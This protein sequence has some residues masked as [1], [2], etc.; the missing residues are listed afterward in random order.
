MAY[1]THTIG[2]RAAALA[3]APRVRKFAIW[4]IAIALALGVLGALV[5]P[6]VLRRVLSDQLTAKLH[7]PVTIDRISINPYAMTATLEGFLMKERNG[8][9][10]AIS[11]DELH[12]NLQLMSLFRWGVVVRE[13]RLVRPYV[14]LV[15]QE[16]FKYN[17]QDLIDEFTAQP[18]DPQPPAGDPAKPRFAFY[19]IQISQGKIDFDDRPEKTQHSIEN[20][21][22][23]IPFI[24]SLPSD[25]DIFVKPAFAA[26]VNGTPLDIKGETKPFKDSL[27]SVVH[28]NIDDLQIP[29]YVEYSPVNLAFTVPSGRIDGKLTA[30]FKSIKGQ[31]ASFDIAADLGLRDLVMQEKAGEPL[32]KLPALDVGVDSFGIFAKKAAVKTVKVQGLEL[33]LKRRK[34]GSFNFANL[35]MA[36]ANPSEAPRA[37]QAD[38]E[39]AKNAATA[40]PFRYQIE[41]LLLESG[42]LHYTDETTGKPYQTRFDDLRIDIKNL[43]NEPGKKAEVEIA[44]ESTA[45]E[46]FSHNGALQLTPLLAE[47]KL[48]V[49]GLRPGGFKPYYEDTLAAEVRDGFLDLSTRYFF[50]QTDKGGDFKLTELAA[51]LRNLRLEE[52]G[53][54]PLWRVPHLAVKDASV[55]AGNKIVV[56]GSLEG[57]EASGFIQRSADGTLNY[58][59]LVKTQPAAPAAKAAVK[60]DDPGW[61]IEAKQIR[62]NRFKIDFEDHVPARPARLSVSDLS[63]RGERFSNIKNQRG[64]ATI[65]AKINNGEVRLN[66][67]A[68]ADPLVAQFQVEGRN[69]EIAPLQPYLED[70]VNFILTGGR[71]GTKGN[72]I[73]DASAQGPAKVTYNGELGVSDFS[74]VEKNASED[75]LNW[76]LLTLGGIQ[77]AADPM[78]VR[79]DQVDLAGFYS[80]LVLGAD[81]KINLQNLAVD[82]PAKSDDAA[83]AATAEPETSQ[84]TAREA[85]QPP[86]AAPA[87]A[88][89]I[90]IGEIKLREGNINFS[91]FFVKPNYTA[92]LTGVQGTIAELK[93]EAPGDLALEAKLDNAAPVDIRGKINPLGKELF[94][95]IKAKASEIELSAFSP[96]SGKYVGYG[97][98]KGQLT[99]D[100]A[101]KLENRKLDA[102]TQFILNQLTFGEKIDSPTAIN[103]PVTLAV[104]LLKDRNGVIDVGLPISGTLDDPQFSVGGIIWRLIVNIITRAVTA[105]FALLGAAFGGGGGAE[106]SYIEFEYGR[107]SLS[108]TAE[109]K[110]KTLATAMNNRPGLKLEITGRAE[111]T[112]DSEGLKRVSL[113]NKVRAQK[114]KELA[115]QGTAPSSVEE[116][117]VSKEEYERL[118]RAAYDAETFPKPRNL[119]GLAQSLPVAEMENLILKHTQISDDDVRALANRRAQEVRERLL[120]ANIA[121]D[122]LFV[123]AG[124]PPAKE[125]PGKVKARPSRVD[126][127]LR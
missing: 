96:Y 48:E 14:N 75:L 62:L 12:V 94:M 8:A 51:T 111:P 26:V 34:D 124:K 121:A 58:A 99:F 27:E 72:F 40:T 65:Q 11:F 13:L 115:R 30:S 83:A 20:L 1:P 6:Y 10:T 53:N 100:V 35:T 39:P 76:K 125:E 66:G 67:S 43:D 38:T 119:I 7:R 107:T 46:R 104:A 36:P 114:I 85:P 81:G 22:L 105:P 2:G 28:I 42:K 49:E 110:I 74:I 113:E 59:R 16:D 108:Q 112:S 126:F 32:L 68:A 5:A 4:F 89:K 97:I 21:Q 55:D 117:Q 116:V 37:S 71:V 88:E 98:E 120:A 73:F 127:S 23:G 63:V 54:K 31:D 123:V 102:Q 44:F 64:K 60:K 80:R 92:N 87:N 52:T 91:D 18:P 15:R 93:P 19:N 86:P 17:F 84:K 3:R 79:I 118:L 9:G 29:K 45:N 69:V 77:F 78:Q 82:K 24:S 56:I 90:S 47:G 106:L 41:Q 61:K 95:D 25:N 101:Y 33:H 57:R 70:Q 109:G 50:Q 122:R 103:L